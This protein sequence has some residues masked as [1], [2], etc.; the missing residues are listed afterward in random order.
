MKVLGLFLL[1]I[2]LPLTVI[3]QN[4]SYKYITDQIDN[5]NLVQNRLEL[6]SGRT[7]EFDNNVLVESYNIEPALIQKNYFD[8]ENELIF[9]ETTFGDSKSVVTPFSQI[10]KGR[11]KEVMAIG[12]ILYERE[13]RLSNRKDEIEFFYKKYCQ[14]LR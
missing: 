5:Y 2:F 3:A 1:I 14:D 11:I 8:F 10:S 7:Y 6:K 13:N 9:H 12:C 4:D